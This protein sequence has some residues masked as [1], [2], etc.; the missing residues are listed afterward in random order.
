MSEMYLSITGGLD[1]SLVAANL[2]KL[3]KEEG[4]EYPIQTFTTGMPGSPDIIAAKQV[5]GSTGDSVGFPY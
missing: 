1:S 3:A 5:L 2:C 4:L